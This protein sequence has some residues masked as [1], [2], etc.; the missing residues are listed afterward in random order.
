MNRT[1]RVR[2]SRT[3]FLI[4]HL[5]LFP[6]VAFPFAGAVD[7]VVLPDSMQSV[8]FGWCGDLTGKT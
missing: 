8:N 2:F 3:R 4:P 1:S 5:L 7:K 6:L